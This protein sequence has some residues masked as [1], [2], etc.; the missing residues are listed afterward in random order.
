MVGVRETTWCVYDLI[1]CVNNVSHLV[2]GVETEKAMEMSWRLSRTEQN[3]HVILL[4]SN[5]KARGFE[6]S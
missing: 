3:L 2:M 6:T 1:C 5:Y 4:A